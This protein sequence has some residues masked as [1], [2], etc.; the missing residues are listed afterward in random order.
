MGRSGSYNLGISVIGFS[1]PE[2]D[3]YIRIGLYQ[4][5]SN[6]Q[7]SWWDLKLLDVLKDWV[8]LV[9]YRNSD[10]AIAEYKARYSFVDPTRARFM[11][12]GFNEEAIEFLFD[13]P[14]EF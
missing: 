3:Q 5:I 2:H 12:G 14:R 4:M 8:R 7:G 6:Y 11:F 9:D 1:L 10:E 13:Q